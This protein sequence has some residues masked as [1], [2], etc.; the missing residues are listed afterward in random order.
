MALD[1][2]LT[3]RPQGEGAV[4]A[5]TPIADIAPARDPGR[6]T[7]QPREGLLD[8]DR[9]APDVDVFGALS[10]IT[11]GLAGIVDQVG[12][13]GRDSR[14][15]KEKDNDALKPLAEKLYQLEQARGQG[16]GGTQARANAELSA[17][18]TEFPTL[19]E[20]A[21]ELSSTY[22]FARPKTT[23]QIIDKNREDF[24]TN[25]PVGEFAIMNAALNYSDPNQQ[26]AYTQKMYAAYQE[27]EANIALMDQELRG[28]K[29]D[30]DRFQ[31]K[32]TQF[33]RDWSSRNASIVNDRISGLLSTDLFADD[34]G[35]GL[36]NYLEE[37]FQQ[38]IQAQKDELYAILIA[39]AP[40]EADRKVVNAAI[41]ELLKPLDTIQNAITGSRDDLIK[42]EQTL[43]AKA[44]MDVA[45]FLV[46]RGL[47]PEIAALPNFI[48][49]IVEST[50][51]T[52]GQVDAAK[53]REL[54][55]SRMAL[56][57]TGNVTES[58][59]VP[60]PEDRNTAFL[61]GS[62]SLSTQNGEIDVATN[63]VK[64][65]LH[66]IQYGGLNGSEDV[67]D[68]AGF[69]TAFTNNKE[70][71]VPLLSANTPAATELA[72]LLN[73][74]LVVQFTRNER[75]VQDVLRNNFPA[76]FTLGEEG[77]KFILQFNKEAFLQSEDNKTESYKQILRIANL[78]PTKENILAVLSRRAGGI[79]DDMGP[80]LGLTQTENLDV[81][82]SHL[83]RMNLISQFTVGLPK[84][85]ELWSSEMDTLLGREELPAKFA[86]TTPEYPTF[87][88][89]ADIEAA[90][91]QPGDIFIYN[92]EAYEVPKEE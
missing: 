71:Y 67:L 62:S 20:A 6:A 72:N 43:G 45:N 15:Q 69:E 30:E 36:A 61:L 2:K 5:P 53:I 31:L 85:E 49:T 25:N 14:T 51:Y 22:G 33:I 58:N 38:G 82:N 35:D 46:E 3:S 74:T 52:D 17:F 66:A 87:T 89:P 73:Q 47:P 70:N 9:D 63:N 81:L 24:F 77:G 10:R 12:A 40:T 11:G 48:P 28:L 44:V 42:L 59:A 26:A 4:Q 65:M 80:R 21:V 29:G 76:G 23:E 41:N 55:A 39:Q 60:T 75:R 78:K 18:L 54:V 19:R 16:V 79:A 50:I 86:D 7:V 84:V 64:G 13:V 92:G 57:P 1:P 8:A 56:D 83:N 27:N 68:Q 91:L 90:G 37:D 34:D 32:Q 88:N